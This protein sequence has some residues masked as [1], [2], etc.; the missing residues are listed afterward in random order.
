VLE[1]DTVLRMEM[2][3]YDAV[4]V[5]S[6]AGLKNAASLEVRLVGLGACPCWCCSCCCQWHFT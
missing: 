3:D 5:T 2:F 6:F 4:N 1:K